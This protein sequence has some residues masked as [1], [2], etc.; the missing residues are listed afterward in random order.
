M[1]TDVRSTQPPSVARH[2]AV[3]FADD[4]MTPSQKGSG[5]ECLSCDWN[6]SKDPV[7]DRVIRAD[8]QR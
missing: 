5:R 7:V 8:V 4:R 6:E 2:F 1:K 3:V